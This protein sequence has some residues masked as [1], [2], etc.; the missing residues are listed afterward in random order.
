MA[1]KRIFSLKMGSSFDLGFENRRQASSLNRKLDGKFFWKLGW[2]LVS[3]HLKKQKKPKNLRQ[4]V[5]FSF[6][7]FIISS[8]AA[9]GL[10]QHIDSISLQ[11]SVERHRKVQ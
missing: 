4:A 10:D 8:V 2:N 9:F 1:Y 3:Q 11:T 5:V 7:I 6:S